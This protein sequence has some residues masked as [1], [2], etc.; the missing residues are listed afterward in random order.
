MSDRAAERL[1]ETIRR[2]DLHRL[3]V[4]FKEMDPL[5]QADRP[6]GGLNQPK[7]LRQALKTANYSA[8]DK[9]W[10]GAKTQSLEKT[11]P[12]HLSAVPALRCL[13]RY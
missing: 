3:P 5:N 4:L 7:R 10:F 8:K 1:A 2:V 12:L 13:C 6:R 9:A 11:P